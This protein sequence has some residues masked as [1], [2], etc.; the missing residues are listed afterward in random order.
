MASRCLLEKVSQNSWA[1]YSSKSAIWLQPTFP[2]SLP[3]CLF[4]FNKCLSN[5]RH[6]GRRQ[7]PLQDPW[8]DVRE[9]NINN[10]SVWKCAVR[11]VP[12]TQTWCSGSTKREL[13]G[14]NHQP[15]SNNIM[16]LSFLRMSC[17]SSWPFK[18]WSLPEMPCHPPHPWQTCIHS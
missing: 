2:D 12:E 11:A 8:P 17:I 3:I 1:Y 13:P 10:S 4:K 16:L 15:S 5:A 9:R 6:Y 14:G 7:R 18:L